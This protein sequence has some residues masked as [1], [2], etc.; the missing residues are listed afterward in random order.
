QPE[1]QNPDEDS[2]FPTLPMDRLEHLARAAIEQRQAVTADRDAGDDSEPAL[3][4]ALLPLAVQPLNAKRQ[5][6]D[7]GHG[8]RPAQPGTPVALGGSFAEDRQLRQRLWPT[9]QDRRQ[10]CSGDESDVGQAPLIAV[11]DAPLGDSTDGETDTECKV[12]RPGY[13][14]ATRGAAGGHGE[15]GRRMTYMLSVGR[16]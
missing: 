3:S 11:V 10:Q 6:P 13:R 7:A 4:E 15:R 5:Q 9:E 12:A 8:E 1:Q 2:D 16:T 14:G